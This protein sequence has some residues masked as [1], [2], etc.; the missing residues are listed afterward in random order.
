MNRVGINTQ[1]AQ[2]VKFKSSK[3]LSEPKEMT[4]KP[5]EGMSTTSKVL[6]GASALAAVAIG[7]IALH[8]KIKAK[9]TINRIMN[10][11]RAGARYRFVDPSETKGTPASRNA[12]AI[13]DRVESLK[14]QENSPIRNNPYASMNWDAKPIPREQAL[15]EHKFPTPEAREKYISPALYNDIEALEQQGYK[16]NVEHLKNGETKIE[17]IYPE[18]SPIKSKV[19]TG[20][21]ADLEKGYAPGTEDS[22][23]ISLTLKEKENTTYNLDIGRHE[24]LGDA[25]YEFTT[26]KYDKDG[27][28]EGG[29]NSGSFNKKRFFDTYIT[30]TTSFQN[31]EEDAKAL[32][33]EF[34]KELEL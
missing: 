1:Q 19:V 20:K 23:H 16:I 7:G 10:E 6:I 28:W 22:K 12:Q 24:F 29:G 33:A 2:I 25:P 30:H 14:A 27:L 5:K 32:R 21:I 13:I 3:E 4:D 34:Q 26:V 17:Y 8:N 9:E 18:E 15:F 31:S 11:A